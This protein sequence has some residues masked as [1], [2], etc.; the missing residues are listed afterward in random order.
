M[1]KKCRFTAIKKL[2]PRA[3]VEPMLADN[4]Q[5]AVNY[6]KKGEQSKEEWTDLKT[7]GPNYGK[8][9][10]IVAEHGALPTTYTNAE[11]GSQGGKMTQEKYR[12]IIKSAKTGNFDAIE[13]KNPGHFV[14]H[15]QTL[16][17]I[18]QD[19]QNPAKDLEDVCGEWFHGPPNSGKSTTA[20]AE[21]PGFYDKPINKWWDGY[22][23]TEVGRPV[24]I[25]ELAPK[26]GE[27]MGDFLK[28]WA[29]RFSFPAEQKG[30]TL[31]IRP[32]K[33][34]VTSNYT[35]EEVFGNIDQMLYQAVKRRFKVREFHYDPNWKPPVPDP[36][37][38]LPANKPILSSQDDDVATQ[39]YADIQEDNS[40]DL[41][42]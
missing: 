22:R 42:Q 18:R 38:A 11:R 26:H 41:F 33:I 40:E 14:R 12:E 17:R 30:T 37:I 34:V 1:E 35:I 36:V 10:V 2:L 9:L 6:C 4:P 24:I 25:E 15:Y 13:E 8:N 23:E 3:H 19:Y 29:D 21:N 31:Q 39:F 32:T 27:F 7:S 28:R 5:D 20:R 16:R